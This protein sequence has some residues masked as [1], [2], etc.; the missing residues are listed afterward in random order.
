VSRV[1]AGLTLA[2]ALSG[3]AVRAE[4]PAL[5][6]FPTAWEEAVGGPADLSFLLEAPA[7]RDGFVT[8]RDGHLAEADGS[9]LRIWGI[10]LSAAAGL[11]RKE[12]APRLAAILARHGL[13]GVR[14]HYFDRPAPGGILDASRSDTRSLDP[15]QLDRFDFLV[16]ELKK[17]GIYTNINLNVARRYRE[18]DGVRDHELLGFAKG[19]THVDERLIELQKEYARQLLTHRNPYTGAEYR[20]EPAVVLVEMVNENSLVE[21]WFAGRLL[22][23]NTTRDPGTW[24]DIPASYERELTARYQ[25][26]LR[27]RRSDEDIARLRQEAGVEEGENVPRLTPE[28]FAEASALRF[29]TEAAFYMEL[30]DRFFQQMRAFLRDELGVRSLLVGSSD[31]NHSRS[32]YPLLSSTAKLDVVDGH[33]YWQ[34]PHYLEGRLPSG[35]SRFE[36]PNTPMVA[37]PL[38]STVVQLARS[39]VEGMP[40]TVSEVNHP[41]PHEYSSEGIPILAAYG[42]LQD[43]DG[44]FWYTFEHATPDEWEPRARGHFDLRPDPVKMAQLAAG[45]LLFLRGDVAPARGLH[46]RSY[47]AEEVRESVRLPHELWPFFTAGFDHALPLRQR[48]RIRD[49]EGGPTD[50][51]PPS[52]SGPIVSDTEQLRWHSR[53]KLGLVTVE[54]ERSEMVVGFPGISPADLRHLEVALEN[55]FAAVTLSALDDRPLARS[56]RL[57][58][59]AGAQVANSGMRWNED[60]TGLVEWGGSPTVIEP[61]RGRVVLRG[62][63]SASEVEV[64][65]LD[66]GGRRGDAARS[67]RATE[68]GWEVELGTPATVWY[69]VDVGR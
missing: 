65:P 32:G 20:S 56:S 27:D 62:L 14:F 25:T 17:Q 45:A 68:N 31:H 39:A 6:P 57:L 64:T 50:S 5:F 37:D 1:I 29:H 40:Y 49:F 23:K 47:A 11:P 33:V 8:V 69:V 42:A 21:S 3:N 55:D 36:I 10:N 38:H 66:S 44:I 53:Q 22:G 46:L 2:L 4:Q 13:N 59:T 12:D 7:G 60:R 41:F 54:T 28:G 52:P 61:V 9:R 34:H 24:T 43:W 26:W 48:T 30:E 63:R 19:L 51:Q 67:A 18:G 35:Q 16:A 15:E 58:L